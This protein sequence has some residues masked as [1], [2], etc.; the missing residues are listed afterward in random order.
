MAKPGPKPR[1]ELPQS[2]WQNLRITSAEHAVVGVYCL[3]H[4]K[5]QMCFVGAAVDL[6]KTLAAIA[7]KLRA[8]TMNNRR[9]QQL[10]SQDQEL[11]L[12]I[13]L[14]TDPTVPEDQRRETASIAA[15]QWKVVL[16]DKCCNSVVHDSTKRGSTFEGGRT[17]VPAYRGE[18]DTRFLDRLWFNPDPQVVRQ[19]QEEAV[20]A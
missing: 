19:V 10:F 6:F 11:Q 7:S 8:G 17:S 3:K 1:T 2:P 5:T 16:A 4:V 15:Y 20:A 14:F 9:F 18:I 12:E 13:K